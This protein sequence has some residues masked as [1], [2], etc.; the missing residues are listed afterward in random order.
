MAKLRDPPE[1][2]MNKARLRREESTFLLKT[3]NI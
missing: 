2:Q 3:Y 1:S